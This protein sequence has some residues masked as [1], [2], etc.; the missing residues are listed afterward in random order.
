LVI[1]MTF[2][3]A[4]VCYENLGCFSNDMP[5]SGTIERPISRLPWSPEKINAR[6]LLF[7]REN[8]NVYQEIKTDKDVIAASQYKPTRKT[9]FII[10]GFIDKGDEN[11]LLDMCLTPAGTPAGKVEVHRTR[12][13][14]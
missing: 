10:H 2:T 9:R 5:W 4:Q 6:F 8:L 1:Y 3:C 14:N 11:W 7:T 12:Q 13:Q